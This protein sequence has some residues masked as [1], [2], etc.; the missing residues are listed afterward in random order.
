M[1]FVI[2]V[3]IGLAWFAGAVLVRLCFSYYSNSMRKS[4]CFVVDLTEVDRS[5]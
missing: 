3:L 1:T 4:R 5:K 2:E